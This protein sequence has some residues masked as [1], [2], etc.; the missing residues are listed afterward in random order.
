MQAWEAVYQAAFGP[1]YRYALR[2]CGR[3]AL[4]EDLCSQTFLAAVDHIH[5]FRGDSALTSW[6]CAITRNLYF[7]HLRKEKRLVSLDSLPQY[8][9][10]EEDPADRVARA[11]LAHQARLALRALPQPARQVVSLRVDGGLPFWDIGAL[12]GRDQNWA[13]VT[14]HRALSRLREILSEETP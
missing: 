1:V 9:P 10:G 2:L 12:F 7:S 11:D 13:C 8:D 5:A 3:P 14:Y 4:A 6:L